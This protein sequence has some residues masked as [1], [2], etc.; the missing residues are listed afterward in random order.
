MTTVTIAIAKD[1]T[2]TVIHIAV[3]VANP[4]RAARVANPLRAARVAN[5]LRV[6]RVANPLAAAVVVMTVPMSLMSA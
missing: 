1:Q 3:E 5:P 2:M 6:A 4:L